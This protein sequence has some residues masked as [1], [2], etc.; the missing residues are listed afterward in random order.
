MDLST[1]LVKKA[2]EL[3]IA[4]GEL[5]SIFNR[6]KKEYIKSYG[7]LATEDLILRAT[8]FALEGLARNRVN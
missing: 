2:A 4:E 1:E 7:A 3:E 5:Q 6:K 8:L